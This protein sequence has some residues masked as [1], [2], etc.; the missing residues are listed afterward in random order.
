[1]KS[2]LEKL[3]DYTAVCIRYIAFLVCVLFSVVVIWAIC[4]MCIDLWRG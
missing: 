3:Q 2:E 1:M 4:R